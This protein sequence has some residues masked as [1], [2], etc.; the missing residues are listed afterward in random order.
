MKQSII[1]FLSALAFLVMTLTVVVG[2]FLVVVYQNDV[3]LGIQS[4]LLNQ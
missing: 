2:F 3:V 4:H 1:N